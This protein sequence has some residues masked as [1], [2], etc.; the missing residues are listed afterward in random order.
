[1]PT[2]QKS[3]HPTTTSLEPRSSS[4]KN[5][6]VTLLRQAGRHAKAERVARCC[7]EF[8][9]QRCPNRH[10]ARAVP[11]ERCQYRLCP[12]CAR[13]R[14]ARAFAR[15]LP[16]VQ[17]LQRR[18]PD[19]R[20][21]LITLTVVSTHEPV[22]TIVAR[23]QRHFAKLRRAKDWKRCIRGG[24]S[25]TE[26][27]YDPD[28]G[29]HVHLH[30][31]AAR[32]AWWAQADLAAAWH[33][34]SDGEGRVVDIRDRHE[35]VRSGRCAALRYL[36]KP[37]T[38]LGWGPDQVAE[39]DALARLKLGERY[40]ALRGLAGARADDVESPEAPRSEVGVPCPA[41]GMPLAWARVSRAELEAMMWVT[42]RPISLT[43][44]QA[45]SPP[46][47]RLQAGA[48]DGCPGLSASS[49]GAR[50]RPCA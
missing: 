40:G 14:Q 22:K 1:M 44:A 32:Q 42:A 3:P 24:V 47:L 10:L 48:L 50:A 17:T 45:T 20:W 5:R 31:L 30:V 19:D 36:F 9:A 35:D 27:T 25:G 34:A 29:W 26:I 11:V 21:V 8:W 23:V 15:V 46:E 4:V 16:A 13:W 18:H 6:L 49:P 37:P 41:C 38:L 12:E 43:T 2:Y 28:A 7:A 33:R 39:F